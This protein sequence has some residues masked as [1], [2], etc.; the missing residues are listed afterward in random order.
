MQSILS[1]KEQVDPKGLCRIDPVCYL[2]L[3]DTCE[4]EL[5]PNNLLHSLGI[6]PSFLLAS[7]MTELIGN[8]QM[9]R[10]VVDAKNSA[11]AEKD[12]AEVILLFSQVENNKL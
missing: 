2:G 6:S 7:R 5:D 1:K 10:V 8:Q 4:R 3:L 12:E 11:N 9:E